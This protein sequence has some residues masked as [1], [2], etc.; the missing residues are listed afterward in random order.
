[1]LIRLFEI[2]KGGSTFYVDEIE[3]SSIDNLKK[4]CKKKNWCFENINTDLIQKTDMVYESKTGIVYYKSLDT[5]NE[6]MCNY[7]GSHGRLCF[8]CYGEI[9]EL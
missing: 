8:L 2:T 4:F 1:M 5:S 3:A 6:F 7:F 9:V